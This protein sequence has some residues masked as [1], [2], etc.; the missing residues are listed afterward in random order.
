MNFGTDLE[1]GDK[2]TLEKG[3]T[4]TRIYL[5]AKLH[6]KNKLQVKDRPLIAKAYYKG[7]WTVA[8]ITQRLDANN[9]I[10][11]V[12]GRAEMERRAQ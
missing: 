12:Y 3:P 7:R 4:D 11:Q 8:A 2:I 1:Y 10:V 6:P 9:A 5:V